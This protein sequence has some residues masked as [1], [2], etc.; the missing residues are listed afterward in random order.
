[1]IILDS[2]TKIDSNGSFRIKDFHR[3][4]LSLKTN[5]KVHVVFLPGRKENPEPRLSEL[6]ISP[7]PFESWQ[8]LTRVNAKA[9]NRPGVLSKIVTALCEQDLKILYSASGP[10]ENGRHQRI[11]FIID[12]SPFYIKYSG[13]QLEGKMRD[14]LIL[15]D[16][17]VWLK[18]IMIED[19]LFDEKRARLKVRPMESF[20]RT[21]AA[22]KKFEDA[23]DYPN[24]E[25]SDKPIGI[26]NGNITLPGN[27]RQAIGPNVQDIMLNSDTKDRMLRG[28]I[29]QPTVGCT[30]VRVVHKDE[31]NALARI[32]E[33]LAKYFQ[34]VTSLTRIR[35]TSHFAD[36]EFML[37]NREYPRAEDE[38]TRRLLAEDILSSTDL[39]QYEIK[40]GYP[41]NPGDS[42]LIPQP[43]RQTGMIHNANLGTELRPLEKELMR[44][45]AYGIAKYKE[46]YYRQNAISSDNFYT[47][48]RSHRVYEACRELRAR[49]IDKDLDYSRIFVSFSSCSRELFN[50]A[51]T[52]LEEYKLNIITAKP[53]ASK[54]LMP[55][56]IIDKIGS[57]FGFIGLWQNDM[58]LESNGFSPMLSWELGIAQGLGLPVRVFPHK[59]LRP[60]VLEPHVNMHKQDFAQAFSEEEFNDILKQFT[61]SF[62]ADVQAYERGRLLNGPNLFSRTN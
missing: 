40:V 59:N 18:G 61:P 56:E 2:L 35:E 60:E 27:I 39:D 57:C 24:P 10:F 44:K 28:I 6:I 26:Y 49:L 46:E 4:H 45:N 43:P 23:K 30:Y 53:H 58:Q 12:A 38:E 19:L 8:Y 54:P 25:K 3:G 47:F 42:R 52:V 36:I 55:N 17:E 37:F 15:S 50:Q 7:I 13:L 9:I 16:L 29:F 11:E 41:K 33:L 31:P 48:R 62:I 51:R 1:M 34:I 22:Y 21:F 32:A 14:Y 20:R 5:T